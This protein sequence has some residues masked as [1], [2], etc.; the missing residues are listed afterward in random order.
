MDPSDSVETFSCAKCFRV[1]K[2]K[3]NLKKHHEFCWTLEKGESFLK[4]KCHMT[5]LRKL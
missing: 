3:T 5:F 2:N 4:Y 1:F